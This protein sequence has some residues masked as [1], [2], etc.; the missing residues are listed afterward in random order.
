MDENDERDEN[1]GKDGEWNI[2]LWSDHRAEEEAKAI[3]A[4][5]EGVLGFVGMT[6]GVSQ[7]FGVA[8]KV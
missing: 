4:T 3:T 6:E 7:G 1:L 8:L 5:K 2:V